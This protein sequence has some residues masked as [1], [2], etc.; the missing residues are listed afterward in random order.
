MT[1]RQP[2]KESKKKSAPQRRSVEGSADLQLYTQ[3][4]SDRTAVMRSSAMRDLMSIT[5]QSDVISLAGGLPDTSTFP[6]T[7]FA[8]IVHKIAVQEC[9]TA[10]QYGPTEGMDGAKKAAATAMAAE[11]LTIDPEEIL[12]T[13]GGQQA[14]DLICKTLLNPGDT[15][16]AEAPT[17]PGAVPAFSAYEADVKQIPVDSE[18]LLISELA[19]QIA[20]LKSRGIKPKFIYTVPNFQ[21]PAGVT[22]SLK[23]REE[24]IQTARQEELLIV[25]DNPYG[26]LRYEGEPLPTL[27]E[28]E[29]GRLVIYIGTF[30]K[31]LS[32]GIRLGWI[33]APGPI[34]Q[35][36]NIG[37][38]AADLCSNTLT[39]LFVDHYFAS[40]DWLE[41]LETVKQLYLKRRDCMLEAVDKY[42]PKDAKWTVPNGGLFL[43]V[44]L[45]KQID[46]TDLLARALRESVAFV[47]GRAAYVDGSGQSSMRLNF[48][49]VSSEDIVEGVKRIGKVINAQLGLFGTLSSRSTAK[50]KSTNRPNTVAEVLPL[51]KNKGHKDK[52]QGA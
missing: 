19:A 34:T 35:K 30:S 23:R 41:Q 6:T 1:N 8:S 36:I 29:G 3:L 45:P 51:A 13:T 5:Q 17:Y 27:R 9:A 11:G 18:G 33:T 46:T 52:G 21:N 2:K 48:S 42:F 37:K 28:L 14:I 7:T 47:P 22:M 38:Q 49:G 24:L 50:S 32:P 31:I 4:M 26:L 25:E 12:V 40:D 15:V 44:T 39:Q 43:W 10:L 20:Q 16:V